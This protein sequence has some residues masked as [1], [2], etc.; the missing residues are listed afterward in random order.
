MVSSLALCICTMNR[1]DELR[2][3]LQSVLEGTGRP[4]QIIV[5]DDGDGTAEAVAAEFPGVIYQAG[6]RRGLPANRNACLRKLDAELVAFIDDDV[7]VSRDFIKR[8]REARTDRITTGWELNFGGPEPR[9]VQPSNASFLGFQKSLPRDTYRSIVINATVFPT[10][11]FSNIEFD[12]RVRYGYEEIDVA[13]HALALGWQITLD[14]ELWVEHHP[15]PAN[16]AAYAGELAVS[17][18]YM[19]HKAYREYERN[20]PKAILFNLVG[21]A[22]FVAFALRHR[23]APKAIASTLARVWRLQ[24]DRQAARRGRDAHV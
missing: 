9:R 1:P 18:L 20:L 4:T 21:G 19:T 24:G 23:R 5:S 16:R 14:V 12:E 8:A 10:H 13:R 22:H 2:T 15:S 3:A 7:R 17:R 6:P 11:V